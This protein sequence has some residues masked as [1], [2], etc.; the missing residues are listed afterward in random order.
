MA[1]DECLTGV[2]Q[3]IREYTGRWYRG[4]KALSPG[5]EEDW[6]PEPFAYSFISNMLPALVY[7]IPTCVV[8]AR[9]VIGHKTVAEAMQ[10]GLISWMGDVDFKSELE[11]VVVDFLFFQ[12]ILM[13]FVEDD[14]RWSDG[15]VRPNTRRIDFRRWG[16]DSLAD[17]L[18]ATAFQFHEAYLDIDDLAADPAI[19]Q[20]AL[21]KCTPSGE[22]G[23]EKDPYG[24]KSR[25]VMAR[26]RIKVHSV[27]MRENNTIRTVCKAAGVELYPERPYYGDPNQGPYTV[28]Q[29][30]P[31]PGQVYPLSPLIAVQDQVNTLQIHARAAARA[32]ATRKEV[33]F[34]EGSGGNM[35]EMVKNSR[36]QEVLEFQGAGSAEKMEFGGVTDKTYEYL[37]L[38]REVLGRHAGLTE[39]SR[40]QVSG[41]TATESQIANEALNNRTEYLKSRVRD[42]TSKTLHTI[43]WFLF[44]TPGI[45]IPVSR[46]DPMTGM[47]TEGLFLGGVYPGEDA[48][49]WDDYSIRIEPLSMQRVSEETLQRR[50]IDFA[51]YITE[52]APIMPQVPWVKWMEVIRMVGEAMNQDNAENL[53]SPE[54]IG[55]MPTMEGMLPS[56]TLGPDKPTDRYSTPG[57]GFKPQGGSLNQGTQSR[58]NS[59]AS[60]AVDQRRSQM[61]TPFGNQYGGTQGP[62]GSA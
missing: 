29:A 51:N 18:T 21:A 37:N 7:A 32:A 11:K 12:G 3:I 50:A 23:Q 41:G 56:Q 60:A 4:S 20:D 35:G 10:S 22:T 14:T 33:V 26:K 28:F 62:P 59:N 49:D 54:L 38:Q 6:N 36:D 27:W 24:G 52:V 57:Q 61:S 8:H 16:A 13:H 31:V 58:M 43:G 40:G 19:L 9:R 15:A 44:H 53:I 34:T 45:V 17:S 39:T 5:L 42:S 55:L 46:R 30:Y 1:R 47:E 2:N 25:D 48:G